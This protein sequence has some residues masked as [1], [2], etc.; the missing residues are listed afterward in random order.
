LGLRYTDETQTL[1]GAYQNQ[2][3]ALIMGAPFNNQITYHPWTYRAALDHQFTSDIL[4]YASFDH[5]FKS[6]GYNAITPN[7]APFLPETLNAYEVGMKSEFASRVRFNIAAFYY[8]YRNIQIA[9]VPGGSG[10]IFTNAGHARNY[11]TDANLDIIASQ[12]LKFSIGAGYLNAKYLQYLN[13]QGFTALGAAINIP[14][15][16]GRFL[17]FAPEASGNVSATYTLPTSVGT[18]AFDANV[19][20]QSHYYI[21]PA[22][23]PVIPARALLA[24]SI[25]WTADGNRPWGIRVWG[26]NLTNQYVGAGI[27]S[28]SGGW[29]ATYSEPRVFGVDLTKKF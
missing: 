4:G 20:Y 26:R 14:N 27:T 19:A 25:E 17:S 23:V 15:A 22:E 3:G 10:Q 2:A 7:T 11:G 13:A 29:Y 1:I 9:I 12:N 16:A 5:G 18:F 28:S 8:D 21:S 6:G 24:S